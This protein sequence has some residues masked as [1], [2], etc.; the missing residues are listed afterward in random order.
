MLTLGPREILWDRQDDGTL[1]MRSADPL[2]PYPDR[3]TDRLFETAAAH[4]DRVLIARREN[5][6]G[7]WQ[8]VTYGQSAP[9]ICAIARALHA[10]GLSAERPV[11]ILSGSSVEHGLLALGALVAG[12][13]YASVTPAYSLL[14]KTHRKLVHVLDLLT[15]G[16]VFVQDRAPFA[17]A[18]AHVAE[19]TEIVTAADLDSLTADGDDP[20]PPAPDAIAKFIFTSGSTGRPK[21]ANRAGS[22]LA[23]STIRPPCGRSRCSRWAS[24]RT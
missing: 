21:G 16:L 4:P 14:D 8:R 18:L 22:P 24:M 11:V 5:G 13:P 20:A 15:P 9:R 6:T 3:L 1:R 23:E 2:R 17:A 19:E 12:V 10:R 7:D